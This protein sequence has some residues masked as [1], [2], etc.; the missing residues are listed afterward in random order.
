MTTQYE[1]AEAVLDELVD[2][3]RRGDSISSMA[4]A[5]GLRREAVATVLTQAGHT[6]S[7]PAREAVLAYVREHQGLSVD[8]LSLR[9]DISKSSI[10][11]YLRGTSEHRL[12]VSRKQTDLSRF[13]DAQMYAALREAF[14]MLGDD[15][16]K[17]LSRVRY[18]RLMKGKTVPAA[19]TYIRR[20]ASWSRACELAG[21]T[22]AKPRRDNYVQEWS[23]DD[24]LDAV[25]AY[26]DATGDTTY[27]GYS[28]WARDSNHPS[29]PLLI[30]RHR[31]WARA[32]REA[33]SR[34]N[35]VAA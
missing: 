11:R 3:H 2:A 9:L 35:V 33:L 22:A 18:T 13:S 23:D 10:S 5:H 24:I 12:V 32:R 4:A 26:V 30:T 6:A 17:G 20:Y 21:I 15:R 14:R 28:A 29:G 7:S 8:D 27:H 31:S 1:Q 34:A 19:S 25:A 16:S